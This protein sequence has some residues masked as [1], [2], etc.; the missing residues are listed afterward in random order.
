MKKT[1]NDNGQY[2]YDK[3]ES[4]GLYG[5]VADYWRNYKEDEENQ[6]TDAPNQVCIELFGFF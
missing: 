2:I 1:L 5:E 4:P 6:P 3:D